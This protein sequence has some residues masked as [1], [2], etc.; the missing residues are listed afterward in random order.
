MG[1]GGGGGGGKKFVGHCH[2][3][4]HEF[5]TIQIFKFSGGGGDN[6]SPLPLYETLVSTILIHRS[7]EYIVCVSVQPPTS[8]KGLLPGGRYLRGKPIVL[9]SPGCLGISR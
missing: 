6:S 2:S 1:G 4:I 8:R 9:Q 3:V 7:M 5:E